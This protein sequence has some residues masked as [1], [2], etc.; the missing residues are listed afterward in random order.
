MTGALWSDLYGRE[1]PRG[2]CS[3]R[4]WFRLAPS[5]HFSQRSVWTT[6][7]AADYAWLPTA[8]TRAWK[9][10]PAGQTTWIL[11]TPCREIRQAC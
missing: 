3:S 6:G 4:P 9:A 5:R 1:G 2:K 8:L 7:L 11:S 10:N